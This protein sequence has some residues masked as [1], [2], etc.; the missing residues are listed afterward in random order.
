MLEYRQWDSKPIKCWSS[1]YKA[2]FFIM[3]H[4]N[5]TPKPQ[6]E[7]FNNVRHCALKL[8]IQ[9]CSY[10][11]YL[12]INLIYLTH[13]NKKINI[14]SDIFFLLFRYRRPWFISYLLISVNICPVIS[15]QLL[16]RLR[17]ISNRWYD[18]CLPFS[19]A[20]TTWVLAKVE[21]RSW[22]FSALFSVNYRHSWS[23]VNLCI[24][25]TQHVINLFQF[26][27]QIIFHIH[28]HRF[29]IALKYCIAEFSCG[30]EQR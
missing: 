19:L 17:L 6:S 20:I 14:K 10:N 26:C 15:Y 29:S 5:R 2:Y 24:L 9:K 28:R 22:R 23:F 25:K 12:N 16:K 1:K 13:L 4:L 8:K 21:V 30:K 7:F 3:L 27:V 11:I 18:L